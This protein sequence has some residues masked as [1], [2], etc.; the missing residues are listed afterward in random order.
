VT[1]GLADRKVLAHAVHRRNRKADTKRLAAIQAA[2]AV[3]AGR[4]KITLVDLGAELARLRHQPPRGGE[5]WSVSSVK[6]LVDQARGMGLIV[7]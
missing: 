7:A 2:A 1:E 4:P 3:Y 6:A 5:K